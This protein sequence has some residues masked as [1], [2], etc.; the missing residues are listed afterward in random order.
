MKRRDWKSEAIKQWNSDPCGADESTVFG[1]SEFFA[2]V[3]RRRYN[4]YA[5]W[6]PGTIGFE[7][8]AGKRILEVGFG[9][10]TDFMSFARAGAQCFG[11]D[12]TQAHIE[13]TRRRLLLEGRPVRI[14]RG[15]AED[16]PF[17]DRSMDAVY[18]FGVLHHTPDTQRA[19]DEI[20]RVLRP[21]G[22]AVVA[23][24]N[25]DSAFWLFTVLVRGVLKGGLLRLGYRGL[26]S[27]IERRKASDAVP[28]VK[29]HSRRESRRLFAHFTDVRIHVRHFGLSNSR[30][31]VIRKMA[32][33]YSEALGRWLGWYL[34]IRAIKI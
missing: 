21:G 22:E 26:M 18:S 34:V 27:Q 24:Y 5:P 16:L 11:V 31:G 2:Q 4:E 28:L 15:D 29:V 3:E 6:I 14:A 12:L 32:E 20:H 9:L 7:K 33:R 13:A 8:F 10:G 1:T 19:V 30:R 17:T 25:R 23:L